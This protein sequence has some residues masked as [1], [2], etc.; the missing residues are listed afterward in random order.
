MERKVI[1]RWPNISALKTTLIKCQDEHV[2]IYFESTFVTLTKWAFCVLKILFSLCDK[3]CAIWC[4][5]C[6]CSNRCSKR[7]FTYLAYISFV[8]ITSVE[9]SFWDSVNVRKPPLW[10]EMRKNAT[11]RKW[12][13][14]KKDEGEVPNDWYNRKFEAS[15]WITVT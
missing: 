1:S 5:L 3:I 12:H 8:R 9:M 2:S 13:V 11:A 14:L 10:N 7:H 15:V 4:F 6:W